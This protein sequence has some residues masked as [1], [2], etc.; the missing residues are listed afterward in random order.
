MFVGFAQLLRSEFSRC[1]ESIWSGGKREFVRNAAAVLVI[2]LE[3]VE[4]RSAFP[5]LAFEPD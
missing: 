4:P 5:E 3:W 2:D 1:R